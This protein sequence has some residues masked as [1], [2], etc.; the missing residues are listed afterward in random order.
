MTFSLKTKLEALARHC[1][2]PG[3]PEPWNVECGKRLGHISE[4]EFDHIHRSSGGGGDTP[5]NCR[6][7]CKD[8]HRIKTGGTKATSAGSD[9]HMAAKEKRLRGATGQAKRKAKIQSR[10]FP[11]KEQR[12][13]AKERREQERRS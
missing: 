6:P 4:I 2:C 5:D 9:T 11:S 3:L 13:A 10:P 1:R 12:R 7:L 8:C